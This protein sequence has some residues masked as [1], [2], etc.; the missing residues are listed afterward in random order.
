MYSASKAALEQLTRVWAAKYADKGV[1]VYAI[2]PGPTRSAC[3]D[4][5]DPATLRTVADTTALRRIAQPEEIAEPVVFL[6]SDKASYITGVVLEV[7]GG[8]RA[9][10]D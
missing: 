8:R 10:A 1:R 5:L 7:A 6:A 3:T 4:D 2:A 9:I